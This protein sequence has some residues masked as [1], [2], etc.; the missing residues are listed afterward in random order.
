MRGRWS[1]KG[2]TMKAQAAHLAALFLLVITLPTGSLSAGA[3]FGGDAGEKAAPAPAEF[4]AGELLVKF[5][6]GATAQSRS[7]ALAGVGGRQVRTLYHSDIELWA[8]PAGQERAI[9]A[10]L[11]DNTNVVYAEPNYL[12]RAVDTTPNDPSFGNQWA[13]TKIQSGAAWDISTGNV[14]TVIAILDTGIDEGHP[15]LA[16]KI[17]AGYDAVA[18]DGDNIPHDLNGHG[19]HCA[20]IA[21]AITDNGIGVAGTDWYARIM[22]VQVLGEDGSGYNDEITDGIVWAYQHGARVLSMSL[23]G[24]WYS[25]T[26]QDA[27]DA[28]HAGGSLVVAAM[29]NDRTNNWT[30]Y[31]AAYDHVMAVAATAPDDTVTVYSQYGA[32]CDIAAP[33]GEMTYLGDPDGILSTMPT[34][35]VYLNTYHGYAMNYDFLQG[36][37]QATP[38]VAGLA[39]LVWAMHPSWAP[40]LVQTVIENTAV[41][42]GPQGWDVDYGHGRIDAANAVAFILSPSAYLPLV[43]RGAT[44]I[45]RPEIPNGDFESGPV[46]WSQYSSGGYALIL[47]SGSLIVDPHGGSWAAWLGGAPYEVS[48]LQQQLTV[49]PGY[50]ILS[51][52]H[53]IGSVDAC[54]NDYAH[55][56]IDGAILQTYDLCQDTS[57]GGWVHHTVDLGAYSSQSVTVRIEVTTNHS[58]NSNLFIDDVTF[59]AAGAAATSSPGVSVGDGSETENR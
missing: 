9:A 41:D 7:A 32:H 56:T 35:S 30:M 47:D 40:N 31:P 8:V 42:L 10:V 36:T 26:M 17:V 11:G 1:R 37:S 33:G 52:W 5:Q 38:Y 45:P 23:A 28:A 12:Y 48:Y 29:G 54:G 27:I 16:G 58:E 50:S 13:H 21:A 25:Q 15:D 59:S 2:P 18:S 43:I 49:P 55:V 22:P 39:A 24:P 51:Y 34:Y 57:T 6:S 14:A 46:A 19:T 4:K 53:W 20:G 44:G 3:Q